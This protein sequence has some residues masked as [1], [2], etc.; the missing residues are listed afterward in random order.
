M[1][2]LP[3]DGWMDGWMDPTLYQWT[4]AMFLEYV[5]EYSRSKKVDQYNVPPPTT[6]PQT[7]GILPCWRGDS[8]IQRFFLGEGCRNHVV[9]L[10]PSLEGERERESAREWFVLAVI[11]SFL[12]LK[13]IPDG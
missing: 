7:L 1:C 9:F 3:M 5:I 4:W 8:C 6:I 10:D 12:A 2:Y 11:Q 13:R